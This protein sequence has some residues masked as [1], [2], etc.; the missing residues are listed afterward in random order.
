MPGMTATVSVEVDKR[1][2]VLRAPIQAIR[3]TPPDESKENTVRTGEG[4]RTKTG[5]SIDSVKGERSWAGREQSDSARG[6]RMKKR[7]D[8]SLSDS[9]R[10]DFAWKKPPSNAFRARVWIMENGKPKA[11]S[12]M[13]GLMN[14]QYVEVIDGELKEGEQVIIGVVGAQTATASGS[15]NN[16]FQPRM[17][18]G[19]GGGGGRRGL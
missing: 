11:I 9:S 13:R 16:P 7:R 5:A 15:Q 8:R 14:T 19:G 17:P 6:E 10:G 3:F 4:D 12:I 1:A 18:G 2:D